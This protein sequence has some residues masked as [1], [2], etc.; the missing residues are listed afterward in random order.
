MGKETFNQDCKIGGFT[1]FQE[2]DEMK[3]VIAGFS[4]AKLPAEDVSGAV[5]SS[6]D[7]RGTSQGF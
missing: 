7:L 3:I 6:D 2:F 1:T 5:D 4:G